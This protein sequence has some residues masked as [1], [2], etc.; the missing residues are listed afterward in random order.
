MK[1]LIKQPT[2]LLEILRELFA[3]SSNSTLRHMLK[4]G[5]VT[6]DGQV[7]IKAKHLLEIG[8]SVCVDKVPRDI[9]NCIKILYNDRNIIVINKSEGLLSVPLD[10]KGGLN[11]L[12]FLHDHFHTSKIYAVHRLD[13]ECSGVMVFACGKRSE[14]LLNEMFKNHDLKRVYIAIIQGNLKKG[15]G[16]WES[17]LQEVDNYK[18]HVTADTTQ[19]KKATTHY[20]VIRRSKNFSFLEIRLETGRKHQIRTHCNEEGHPIA[21][22]KIYG[23]RS[24]NP[25]SRMCLHSS[26]LE[27]VHPFT[28]KKMRFLAPTPTSFF[29]LGWPR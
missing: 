23:L 18:V 24:C 2:T 10:S 27:L 20:Q 7:V 17:Y 4:H 13:K 15:S 8:Q 12:D 11:A 9:S 22:D 19:G 5:Q 26:V 25:I 29:K 14:M 3:D 21:G 16:T 1:Y 6:V 28:G